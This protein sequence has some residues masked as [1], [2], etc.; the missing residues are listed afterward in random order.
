MP[1]HEIE[2]GRLPEVSK[3][4]KLYVYCRSGSRSFQAKQLL[5]D[6]GFTNVVDL[7]GLRDVQMMGGKL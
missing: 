3:D 5:D 4:T 7:G 6:A 1:L 2:A